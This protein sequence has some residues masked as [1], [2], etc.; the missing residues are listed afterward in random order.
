MENESQQH[1]SMIPVTRPFLPPKSE[2]D[3]YLDGIYAR[4]WLT[5]DGP[6]VRKL[7]SALPNHLGCREMSFVSNGTI[8]L[9]LA[10]RALEVQGE[11][12]T[13]P[14]SYVATTTSIIWERC[15]PRFV[16]IE[17]N[18]FNIDPVKI[19]AAITEKTSAILATHCFGLPCDISEIQNI[20]NRYNL[21]VIY[22]AAHCFG[23]T[24]K[25]QSVFNFGDISTCSFHATKL[26]HTVE[27]GGIFMDETNKKKVSLLRNFGHDGPEKFTGIGINGKNSEFHAA[28]GLAVLPHMGSI[29]DQRKKVNLMYFEQLRDKEQLALVDPQT[30]G[31]NWAYCPAVFQS[32][33]VCLRVKENL[34]KH[35][36]SPRRYFYP[37]LDMLHGKDG[38]HCSRARQTARRILCLPSYHELGATEI[39]RISGIILNTLDS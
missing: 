6:L 9:Q 34:Q 1:D 8:A 15:I 26:F 32:E 38:E 37:S 23:S 33:E 39:D 28:M 27:G 12:I 11:V 24:Y 20:A 7:E 30:E 36:V 5:N 31:W 2:L 13:T 10:I 29:L 18:G 21:V 3:V 35:G 17:K 16:D 22:D 14:F 4:Q 19:E 25:G